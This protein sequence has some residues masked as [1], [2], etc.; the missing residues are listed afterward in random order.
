MKKLYVFAALIISS[1]FL[2]SCRY[3]CDCE[4]DDDGKIE[5]PC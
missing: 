3:E 1:L 2:N 5:C 4:V